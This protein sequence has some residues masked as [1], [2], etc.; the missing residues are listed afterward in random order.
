M[1]NF[2]LAFAASAVGLLSA[3]SASAQSV[4]GGQAPRIPYPAKYAV[5]PFPGGHDAAVRQLAVPAAVATIPLANYGFTATKDNKA[6]NAVIVGQ[7]PTAAAP[8]KTT[9]NVMIVPVVVRIGSH[10]Y[11]PNVG[12]TCGGMRGLSDVVALKQSPLFRTMPYDGAA[13]VGHAARINGVNMGVGTYADQLRRAEFRSL[14]GGKIGLYHTAFNMTSGPM[15]YI[16]ANITNGHSTV[17]ADQTSTNSC[18][19]L[20]GLEINWFDNYIQTTL[21]P[22][23]NAAPDTFVIFLMRDVVMY[24][25][26][27][28]NCCIL[29]YHGTLPNF[30]TYSPIDFDT[31]GLF[32]SGVAD[33][34]V[35]SHE[36]GE[37]LDDPLGTNPTP[38]WGNIGQVSGCQNNWETGDP[39]SGTMFPTISATNGVDYHMQ[40]LAFWGWFYDAHL[41]PQPGAGG[42]F[43]MGGAFAGPS[44]V[45]NANGTGGGTW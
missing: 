16:P 34:S 30:Q 27:L 18:A 24:D 36:I 10:T 3:V 31:T 23:V 7:S 5:K 25:T 11:N 44:K 28:S 41:G 21:L 12:N 42:K 26:T 6:Y 14:L 15:Q 32:G 45:C 29:G 19:L 38:L 8:T 37:W 35:A 9:V 1:R 4:N 20:G 2:V 33:A 39:L 17:V 13:A 43:S 22:A 40:D